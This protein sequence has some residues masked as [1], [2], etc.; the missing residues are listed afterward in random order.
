MVVC[1]KA[2][3]RRTTRRLEKLWNKSTWL[4]WKLKRLN[5]DTFKESVR[6]YYTFINLWNVIKFLIV[7]LPYCWNKNDTSII[8]YDVIKFHQ[9]M[10]FHIFKF[11]CNMLL[12][13]T[14]FLRQ[15]TVY[16]QKVFLNAKLYNHKPTHI[17][18]K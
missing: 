18:T 7:F 9:Y 17:H 6:Q 4:L 13:T 5:F 2:N 15:I 14:V 11:I 12:I 1:H 16:T 3:G 8:Y 10:S